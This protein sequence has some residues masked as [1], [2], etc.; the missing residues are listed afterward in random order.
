MRTI[1]VAADL[2]RYR[3]T[4]LEVLG[5]ACYQGQRNGRR[6]NSRYCEIIPIVRDELHLKATV[7]N[8]LRPDD[9]PAAIL[10][11]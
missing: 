6:T 8:A 3:W 4:A 2:H 7:Y 11:P 9:C 10:N 1:V 5:R